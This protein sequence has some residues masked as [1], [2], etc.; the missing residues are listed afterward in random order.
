VDGAKR[1]GIDAVRFE[2]CAQIQR[3]LAGRGVQW[4]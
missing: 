3:E 4:E 1:E 2:S